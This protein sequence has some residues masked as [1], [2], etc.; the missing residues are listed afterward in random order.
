MKEEVFKWIDA[1]NLTLEEV[2]DLEYLLSLI[3]NFE[4][5]YEV[6][7]EE[8]NAMGLALDYQIYF[9]KKLENIG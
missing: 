3:G 6:E 4:E 8:E 5:N 2:G 1:H 7:F 9:R